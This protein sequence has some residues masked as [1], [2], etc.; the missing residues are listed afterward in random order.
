MENKT[1]P[2]F[3][4]EKIMNKTALKVVQNGQITL[5]NC[6]VPEENRLQADKSFHDT[7]KGVENDTIPC[8]LGG[9]RLR[10]GRLRKCT[11]ILPRSACSLESRSARFNSCK[12]SSQRCLP[13]LLHRSAWWFAQPNC[14]PKEN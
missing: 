8:G 12:T 9:S 10:D 1:T 3:T 2:G 14:M 13:T 5:E 7:A 4:V 11:Q 6:R